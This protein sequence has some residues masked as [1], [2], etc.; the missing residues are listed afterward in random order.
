MVKKLPIALLI[1]GLL[2]ILI[3]SL[4]LVIKPKAACNYNDSEKSYISQDTNCVINFLCIRGSEGFKDECGCGCKAIVQDNAGNPANTTNNGICNYDDPTKSYIKKGSPCIINFLCT[5]NK[6]A[7]S[8]E[9]GCGCRLAN[10][11]AQ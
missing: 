4:M 5:N 9:C 8:D 10:S 11:T 7:F 6:V 2:I 3:A 1:I